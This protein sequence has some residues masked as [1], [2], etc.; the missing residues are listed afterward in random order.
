MWYGDSFVTRERG[1]AVGIYIPSGY[2]NLTV[3]IDNSQG[4]ISSRNSVSI[5]FGITGTP[6][7]ATVTRL[8]GLFRDGF[9]A[10]Y[11]ASWTLGPSRLLWR[12]G[13]SLFALDDATTTAGTRATS[14]N[15]PPANAYVVSK[16]TAL[17]GRAFRGRLYMPGVVEN[18]VDEAGIMDAADQASWQ[19]AFDAFYTAFNADASVTD[20]VLLHSVGSPVENFPDVLTRFV[21]RGTVGSMRPRQRR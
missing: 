19:A 4:G 2:G 3:R 14:N 1:R 7:S 13:G 21:V 5:G 17:A 8:S 16:Q 11:D 12:A 6:N 20:L 10:R 9:K 15:A 18:L